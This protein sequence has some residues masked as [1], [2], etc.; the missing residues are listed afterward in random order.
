MHN[1]TKTYSYDIHWVHQVH[2]IR[3]FHKHRKFHVTYMFDKTLHIRTNNVYLKCMTFSWRTFHF[4]YQKTPL[5]FPYINVRYN[6]T[7]KVHA[8]H[9]ARPA[10]HFTQFETTHPTLPNPN[11]QPS[12]NHHPLNPFNTNTWQTELRNYWITDRHKINI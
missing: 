9:D 8:L 11:P 4:L 1:S 10:Q 2:P 6:T 7:R 12:L 3:D 5:P